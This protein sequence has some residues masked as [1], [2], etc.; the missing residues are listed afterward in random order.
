MTDEGQSMPGLDPGTRIGVERG[1][2]RAIGRDG[3]APIVSNDEHRA[4]NHKAPRW[5]VVPGS[6][7]VPRRHRPEHFL[8][9][10]PILPHYRRCPR[11]GATVYVMKAREV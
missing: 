2:F 9:F 4:T 1:N 5:C 7:I 11:C 3:Y 10:D 8:V 6:G